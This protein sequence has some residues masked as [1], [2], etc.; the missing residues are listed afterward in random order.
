[1]LIVNMNIRGLGGSTKAR[2]LSHIISSEGANFVCIQET[3]LSVLSD[4]R[5]FSLWGNNNVG[6]V[7]YGSDNGSGSLLS[8]W[9]KEAFSYDTHVMGKGFIAVFGQYKKS[10]CMCVV[11]NVYAACSLS[12]KIS[13]WGKLK[14]MKKASSDMVW[15]FYGNFNVVR[16]RCERKGVSTQP[17]R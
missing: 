8:M 11:V 9:H 12:E 2:Y 15:C 7:H 1:M 14:N 3:K 13:L 16:R 17:I 5:C 10:N 6:W 4:A